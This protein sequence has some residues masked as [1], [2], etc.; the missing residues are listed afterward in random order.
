MRIQEF[1]QY[2]ELKNPIEVQIRT[3]T[4]RDRDADY[5]AVYDEAGELKLH[6]IRL[7]GFIQNRGLESVIAHEL[8][9]AWQEENYIEEIH[10]KDFVK[11][12]KQMEKHFH[13]TQ[14][15]IPE[16]DI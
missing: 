1:R 2:L 3:K 14:V 13:L 16:L 12:A 5:R 11:M 15:Y 4:K 10:G 6:I 7:Y 9:H 8:I